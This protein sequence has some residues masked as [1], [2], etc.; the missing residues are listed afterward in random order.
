MS[1]DLGFEIPSWMDKTFFE[2]I[3]KK[4][5]NNACTSLNKIHFEAAS[6]PGDGFA[7]TIFRVICKSDKDY[8]FV[9]KMA[10][11]EEGFKKQLLIQEMAFSVEIQMYNELL[12]KMDKLLSDVLGK[13]IQIG[14]K[15]IYHTLKPSPMMVLEDLIAHGCERSKSTFGFEESTMVI[16]RLA[17]FHASSVFINEVLFLC[18]YYKS[19]YKILPYKFIGN[20]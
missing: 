17:Q 9:V 7:S 3:L 5:T 18:I 2:N 4:H 10:P 11:I 6:K 14:P 19:C 20:S 1:N 15:L 16:K 8:S 13:N 12:P